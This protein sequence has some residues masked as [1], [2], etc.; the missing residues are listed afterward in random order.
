MIVI[1][2]NLYCRILK[3]LRLVLFWREKM[4]YFRGYNEKNFNFF[5]KAL[6]FSN[7]QYKNF[8]IFCLTNENKV[9]YLHCQTTKKETK[10]KQQNQKTCK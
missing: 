6:I 1:D 8:F 4:G 10:W 5:Y 7:I 9:V 3:F 2:I